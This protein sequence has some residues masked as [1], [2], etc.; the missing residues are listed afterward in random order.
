MAVDTLSYR[1]PYS[2]LCGGVISILKDHFKQINGFTTSLYGWGGEDDDLSRRIQ[3]HNLT[4]VRSPANIAR[5]HMLNHDQVL[6]TDNTAVVSCSWD[7]FWLGGGRL[8]FGLMSKLG[9]AWVV[10][11]V[12]HVCM[13]GCMGGGDV[14]CSDHH[15]NTNHAPPH[16]LPHTT[17][18]WTMHRTMHSP[19]CLSTQTQTP[20]WPHPTGTHRNFM[21]LLLHYYLGSA[22]TTP[23]S[24]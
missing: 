21:I 17:M 18:H 16:T 5:F 6:Y 10:A 14:K 2:T 13:E 1:L 24:T 22:K 9:R 8:V 11:W 7:G 23:I 19:V 20:I 15:I 4:V 12:L 3:F